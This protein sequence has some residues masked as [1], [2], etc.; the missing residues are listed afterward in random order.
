MKANVN[1]SEIVNQLYKVFS[2]EAE[3]SQYNN[4]RSG[5]QYMGLCGWAGVMSPLNRA[6]FLQE[7]GQDVTDRAEREAR[8]R[9]AE[10]RAA[11]EASEYHRHEMEADTFAAAYGD[12]Q[13]SQ[14]P[15][16]GS[17]VWCRCSNMKGDGDGVSDQ[18]RHLERMI[19]EGENV[20]RCLVEVRDV[21][22]VAPCD[23][24]NVEKADE[25]AREFPGC[26]RYEEADPLRLDGRPYT[27]PLVWWFAVVPVGS[28]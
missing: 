20:A 17:F 18:L 14:I 9:V 10:Y 13:K 16:V 22:T 15:A 5:A 7:F 24:L 6:A 23:F 28:S 11:Y 19:S 27:W 25:I 2:N 8:A 26:H 3:A 4:T 1:F 21:V 12:P